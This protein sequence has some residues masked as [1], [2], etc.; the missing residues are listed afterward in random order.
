MKRRLYALLLFFA[1][2]LSGGMLR[3]QDPTTTWPY[4]WHDFREATVYLQGGTT[5]VQKV[6][7]HL[8]RCAMHYID[9]RGV[10]CLADLS[11]V[12]MVQAG[13]DILLPV[14]GRMMQ[15]VAQND[16]GCIALERKGDFAALSETGGAYGMG[17]ATS[18]TDR[19]SSLERD[20]QVNMNHMLILSERES[21]DFLPVVQKYYV[22]MPTFSAPASRAE[23]ERSLSQAKYAEYKQWI[24]KNK[25]RWNKPESLL[26]LVDFLAL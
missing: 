17:S 26:Q 2:L 1:G 15:V 8:A 23:F 16:R 9:E 14:S 19:R 24:K 20:G 25:V 4:L 7:V 6:N 18:A 5:V 3:A 22:V 21:G 11:P 13:D 12:V 10:I